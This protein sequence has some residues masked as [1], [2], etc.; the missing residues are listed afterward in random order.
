MSDLD[1]P[2]QRWLDWVGEACAAVGADAD[3]VDI[4]QIH[5]LSKQVAHRLERPLAPVSTFILGLALGAAGAG[6]GAGEEEPA[7]DELLQRIL[8]TLPAETQN[9]PHE[10]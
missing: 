1:H 5:D 9:S 7:G 4:V 6:A 3:A 8:A 10:P 2:P